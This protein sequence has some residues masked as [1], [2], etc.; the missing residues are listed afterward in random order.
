MPLRRGP[1]GRLGVSAGGIGGG[2]AAA[3]D[4]CASGNVVVNIYNA[5]S[6]SDPQTSVS[7]TNSG[8]QVDIMFNAVAALMV[9]D[10]SRNSPISQLISCQSGFGA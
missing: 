8:T 1:D 9:D 5:A 7:R 2:G 4:N 3:N 6:G 10:G